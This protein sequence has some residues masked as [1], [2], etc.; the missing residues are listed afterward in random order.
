MKIFAFKHVTSDR[1]L[2]LD[3]NNKWGIVDDIGSDCF[4]VL[5]RWNAVGLQRRLFDEGINVTPFQLD[6]IGIGM[7]NYIHA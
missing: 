3:Q 5:N 2:V 6:A 7:N 4:F 1:Y